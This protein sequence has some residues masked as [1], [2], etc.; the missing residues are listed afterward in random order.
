VSSDLTETFP[1]D[2]LQLIL[3]R[4]DQIDK[5]V[6][7]IRTELAEIRTELAELSERVD[8]RLQD[9]RPIWEAVN[10]QLGEIKDQIKHVDRKLVA[11]SGTTLDHSASI[12]ELFERVEKLEPKQ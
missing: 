1:S 3:R 4:L 6:A 10:T 9:T 8:Q 7:E 12:G 2:P 11:L 5:N